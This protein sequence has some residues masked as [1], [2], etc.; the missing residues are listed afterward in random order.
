[1]YKGY[2]LNIYSIIILAIVFNL[3]ACSHDDGNTTSEN[4]NIQNNVFDT[5]AG[6]A[7]RLF[8]T[9][10][11]E[12][13]VFKNISIINNKII[14]PLRNAS[15]VSYYT[16]EINNCDGLSMSGND[17]LF[18]DDFSSLN[19]G[20]F[21]AIENS[22]MAFVFR[23]KYMPHNDTNS[24][25][26]S[27]AGTEQSVVED[28]IILSS[29]KG[30][31]TIPSGSNTVIVE[32]PISIFNQFPE[33]IVILTPINDNAVELQASS[34]YAKVTFRTDNVYGVFSITTN[35]GSSVTGDCQFA[36]EVKY[37]C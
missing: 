35:D 14:N 36:Y 22:S 4:I 10:S 8:S 21:V 32:A 20:K 29:Q 15:S 19:P 23:N 25:W 16:L 24:Y 26:I 30:V 12:N 1:M 9:E 2:C 7:I 3:T 13:K 18:T 17:I 34:Q 27:L 28:N 33:A 11:R 37:V 5:L 31:A 6:R